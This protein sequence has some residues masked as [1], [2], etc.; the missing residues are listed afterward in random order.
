MFG[1]I[2][3]SNRNISLTILLVFLGSATGDLKA[4]KSKSCPTFNCRPSTQHWSSSNQ[5]IF[6]DS[7]DLHGAYYVEDNCGKDQFCPPLYESNST[8][9]A[10]TKPSSPLKW[11]GEKCNSFQECNPKYSFECKNQV[12]L[13]A[14]LNQSCN[15]S[16]SCAPGYYCNQNI[17]TKQI[18]VGEKGC[19]DDHNCVNNA[20]CVKTSGQRVGVCVEYMSVENGKETYSCLDHNRSMMCK[21]GICRTDNTTGFSYCVEKP[22]SQETL[23][24]E[25]SDH[26]DC[27][28]EKVQD[29]QIRGTCHCG[30]NAKGQ[31]YC[32]LHPGDSPRHEYLEKFR[33]WLQ[34][35][36]IHNCNTMRRFHNACM[37]DFMKGD[38]LDEFKY[39]ML[40][41]NSFPLVK[42]S[43]DCVLQVY[44]HEFYKAKQD[45]HQESSA[46]V[47]AVPLVAFII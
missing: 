44:E 31:S 45:H 24:V 10:K 29:I 2:K 47:I 19:V 36:Q 39:K 46:I 6:Y 20:G 8:C 13:G 42:N 21:S 28:S 35:D 26:N 11:P 32:T 9:Q 38:N 14:S 40:Y 23:P 5:C 34:S 27:W 43:P 1:N 30:F 7:S 25:C 4:A 16:N 3:M 33:E 41:T 17:C 22:K 37:E 18:P 15:D 12:C